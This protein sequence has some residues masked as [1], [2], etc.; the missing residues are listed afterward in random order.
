VA[1]LLSSPP[2]PRVQCSGKAGSGW[3]SCSGC[4]TGLL[5]L[6]SVMRCDEYNGC[7]TLAYPMDFGTRRH[8]SGS[9]P[10]VLFFFP[11]SG[12]GAAIQSGSPGWKVGQGQARSRHVQKLELCTVNSPCSL[13]VLVSA[14]CAI[15][16]CFARSSLAQLEPQHHV[17]FQLH[18]VRCRREHKIAA[19]TQLSA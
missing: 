1:L 8:G 9:V 2:G 7:S 3:S 5:F 15:W 11:H 13:H 18:V 17:Q 6:L 14:F 10:A 4:S 12:N 16:L 19:E